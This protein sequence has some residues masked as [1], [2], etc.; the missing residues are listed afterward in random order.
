MDGGAEELTQGGMDEAE[1]ARRLGPDPTPRLARLVLWFAVP[2]I[3]IFVLGVLAGFI[4]MALWEDLLPAVLMIG[5]AWAA[6]SSVEGRAAA[7]RSY[8]LAA[9]A[10]R[11]GEL[12]SAWDVRQTVTGEY[13][14]VDPANW[15]LFLIDRV[16][17]WE[18]V[19]R[20]V[21]DGSVVEIAS[22]LSGGKPWRI[23]LGDRVE[24]AEFREMLVSLV[25]DV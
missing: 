17:A 23:D 1:I 5:G 18:D 10:L 13:V 24:A 4:R 12:R 7:V 19:G 3:G 21:Q 15:A 20:I 25:G 9:Q 11:T 2:G 16:I 6:W 8:A 22:R 14:V